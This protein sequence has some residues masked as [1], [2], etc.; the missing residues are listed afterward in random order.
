MQNTMFF[1][2]TSLGTY[3]LNNKFHLKSHFVLPETFNEINEFCWLLRDGASDLVEKFVKSDFST[4]LCKKEKRALHTLVTQKNRVHV[5]ND[6]DKNLGPA[7]ADKSDVIK[8]CKRQLYDVDTYLTSSKEEMELFLLKNIELL[9]RIMDRH[10]YLGNCSQKEK[11]FLLSH[12]HTFVI[13]YVQN[14][15]QPPQDL[16][17]SI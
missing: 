9:R 3:R 8:E 15:H 10:F 11:E 4:N 5:I 14:V 2:E 7:N 13:L 1:S 16:T 17:I 12:V 6:T